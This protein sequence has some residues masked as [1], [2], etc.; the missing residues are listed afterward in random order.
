MKDD[1][2]IQKLTDCELITLY[3]SEHNTGVV[4]E[5]YQRYTKFVFLVSMKYLKDEDESKD[6]AM[7][8]FED[9]IEKILKHEIKHFKSWLY[10]VTVNHCLMILR[11]NKYS[12]KFKDDYKKDSENFM[13]N[14]YDSHLNDKDTIETKELELK[15][16]IEKLKPEHK[17]CIDLFYL[18]E[19]TYT[20]V[21]EI[22][23]YTMKQVKSYIQN[24]K[25]N[26][27]KML[28]KSGVSFF[29]LLLIITLN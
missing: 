23:G 10:R 26:L 29:V 8:I 3:K 21:S 18:Q 11:A 5:L 19:K 24:G 7:Q 15:T 6:A 13:E 1:K 28:L 22:T 17:K 9:L 2:I 25:L 16:A 12:Q 27:K 20:E 4:G 14:E